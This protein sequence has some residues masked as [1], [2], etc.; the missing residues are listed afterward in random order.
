MA[1]N[2]YEILGV[3]KTATPDE[4]KSAYR[5]L[6]RQYHP[7]LHP[8]DEECAKKFKEV[9]EANE[10]LSD[11]EKRKQYD[12][13]LEHP[14][15]TSGFGGFGGGSGGFSGGFSSG[16]FSGGFSDIF[17]DIF[18]Q[19]TGGGREEPEDRTGADITIEVE[20]S[21]LDA[22]KGCAKEVTYTRKEP[23]KDCR[24]TG[25][26]NGTAYKTCEK[27]HGTGSIQYASGNSIFRTISTRA[28]DACGGTGKQII[29]KC[30]TCAGKGYARKSTTVRIDV[31]AG[32]DTGSY[33]K[34]K[35]YG[36]ASVTGGAAGDL[37]LVF[38]V[39]PHKI[40]KRKNYD[41]Y[42]EL[43]IDFKT[44][45]LG[46]TVKVPTIDK[47]VDLDIP[48]GTQ[49]GKVFTVRGKGINSRLGTGNLYV[50]VLVEVPSKLTKAQKQRLMDF[51][52]DV[53]VKQYDK[54]KKY[55][56]NVKAMYGDDPYNK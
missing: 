3:S 25:A 32:A 44:A 43:P 35:G 49:S 7:D 20:L 33:M 55:S 24:G 19:F 22:A 52:S 53:D 48:E 18:S 17:G 26:K 28:C 41:L 56:D 5:K 45:A 1:K 9:N 11:P 50:T 54:M 38:K 4:I 31:P 10:T 2:Y 13:E 39:L 40:F 21:F 23:C 47:T 14:G 12:F 30:A 46:G 15:A 27:C 42:V 37:I 29:E 51:D 36:E 6:A 16:G 34:K 8:N